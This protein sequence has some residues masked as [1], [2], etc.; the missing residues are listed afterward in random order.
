MA[1]DG[2]TAFLV[3]TLPPWPPHSRRLLGT[4]KAGVP[5]T[6]ELVGHTDGHLEVVL[7]W[8]GSPTSFHLARLSSSSRPTRC[9]LTL[10]ADQGQ[11]SVQL[12]G[13]PVPALSSTNGAEF[14]L[15]P[16]KDAEPAPLSFE[17]PEAIAACASSVETR[18][19]RMSL[20]TR[21]RPRPGRRAKSQDE[22]LRELRD[23]A[24]GLATGLARALRGGERDSFRSLAS[25]VRALTYWPDDGPSWN[26]LLFRI[27][28]SQGLPLPVYV[29]PDGDP[30]E[31][32]LPKP[33]YHVRH[34][35]VSIRREI[36]T[37]HVADLETFLASPFETVV[38]DGEPETVTVVEVIAAVANTESSHYDPGV[39]L[40]IDR[41]RTHVYLDIDLVDRVILAVATCVHAL[42]VWAIGKVEESSPS[43]GDDAD[44][45]P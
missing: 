5:G 28:A 17:A 43:T 26:P 44:A 20:P 11:L 27:A 37:F 13:R 33:V 12:N 14:E 38:V 32:E 15:T 16:H 18:R 3:L 10:L 40:H 23:A 22:Q 39:P 36:Q 24:T 45:A 42:S 2:F 7:L 4:F 6:V 35:I 19:L 9:L 29:E 21:A 8:R 1:H 34:L 31:F 41:L 25:Q 30:G